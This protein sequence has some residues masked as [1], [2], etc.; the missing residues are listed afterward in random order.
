MASLT[1]PDSSSPSPSPTTTTAAATSSTSKS[2]TTYPTTIAGKIAF[3]TNLRTQGKELYV[4]KKYSKAARLYA[5]IP[6]W[7]SPFAKDNTGQPSQAEAMTEMMGG[8]AGPAATQSEQIKAKDLLRIAHQNR[9]MCYVKLKKPDKALESCSKAL[10]F[11]EQSADGWKIHRAQAESYIMKKDI[12]NAKAAIDNVLR[13]QGGTDKRTT[14]LL[15]HVDKMQ[16]AYE[17]KER[18]KYAGMFN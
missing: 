9:A 6:S 15:N 8:D 12:D 7:V 10:P 14:M 3:A 11:V 4:A 5:Q 1:E 18:K 2:K 13:I 16:A 17:K